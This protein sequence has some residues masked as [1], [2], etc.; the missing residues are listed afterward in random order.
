M[1]DALLDRPVFETRNIFSF[2]NGNR[3][4]LM[5][6]QRPVGCNSLVKQYCS[7]G[8]GIR[9]Q[10]ISH[11]STRSRIFSNPLRKTC[12]ASQPGARSVRWNRLQ[13]G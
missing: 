9:P 13:E 10:A 1:L 5:P 4:V 6:I 2:R 11:N 8:L 7:N 3:A 12:N